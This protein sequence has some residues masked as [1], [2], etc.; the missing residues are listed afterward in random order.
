MAEIVLESRDL[1]PGELKQVGYYQIGR[2]IGSGYFA[3]VKH[4]KHIVTNTEVAIKIVDKAKLGANTLN[5]V[6]REIDVMKLLCHPHIV[7]LYQV[8]ETKKK[9][10]LVME[11]ANGG[12]IFD[13]L[14]ARGRLDEE[15]ARKKFKQILSAVAYCHACRIVH[16][17]VKAE[18]LLLD[19]N[20]NAKLA[21]FNLCDNFKPGDLLTTFCGTPS[22]CAPEVLMRQKYDGHKADI[23]S[24]GVVLYALVIGTL[25]FEGDSLAD[26]VDENM[27]SRKLQIPFF[28]SFECEDLIK[29]MLTADPSKRATIH[30]ISNHCW[31]KLDG[32]DDEFEELITESLDPTSGEDEPLN[33]HI[34]ELMQSLNFDRNVTV[35]SVMEHKYD[36]MSA[37]YNLLLDRYNT[38]KSERATT[39]TGHESED[40]SDSTDE[41]CEELD[42]N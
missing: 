3:V 36:H 22:Y 25:P 21:D 15:E 11:Y 8:M 35:E 39:T 1:V 37:I 32:K 33:E 7:R 40:G 28:I 17:D 16:R 18:N 23:W 5:M 20:F 27:Q 34:L 12:T 13:H 6:Y 26:I 29:R 9:L 42:D 14:A 38:I 4:A 41:D 30:E 24:L 10:Y 19:S 2:T 31:I